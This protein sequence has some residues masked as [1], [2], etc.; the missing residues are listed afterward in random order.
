MKWLLPLVFTLGCAVT[1]NPGPTGKSSCQTAGWYV[2]GPTS[3]ALNR[4]VTFQ[5]EKCSKKIT[6]GRL[7]WSVSDQTVL[8]VTDS[9]NDYARIKALQYGMADLIVIGPG[10]QFTMSVEVE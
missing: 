7:M 8:R 1:L 2:D 3:I 6:T 10:A 9:G 4:E 5:I